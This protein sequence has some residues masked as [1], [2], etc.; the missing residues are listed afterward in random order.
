MC[1]YVYIFLCMYTFI[2]VYLCISIY[3]YL[4]IY[5]CMHIFKE[6]GEGGRERDSTYRKHAYK[7][8]LG[9]IPFPPSPKLTPP[10]S[11]I[12]GGCQVMRSELAPGCR[13]AC[14]IKQENNMP[15]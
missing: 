13:R 11:L 15:S 2:Y 7:D 6:G 4:Y 9:N 10:S 1:I 8:Y 12:P 14:I 5:I 3:L